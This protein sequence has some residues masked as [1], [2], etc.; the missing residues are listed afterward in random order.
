MTQEQ[1]ALVLPLLKSAEMRR[2]VYAL[3]KNLPITQQEVEDLAGHVIRHT[4]SSNNSQS[5]RVVLLF[6]REHE[7]LW[8]IVRETLRPLTEKDK[9]EKTDQKV[10]GFQ[11]AAGTALF[12]E[13]MAVIRALQKK[14]P[15]Y[16]ERFPDWS[17]HGSA[18]NQYRLWQLL[19][20]AGA[21]ASLQH[22]NPIIDEAVKK[23]W[24]I[25]EDYRLRAQL[26]FGGVSEPAGEKTFLPVE[27]RLKVFGKAER[28]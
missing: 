21:G 12:F 14:L 6:G 5:A 27:E 20:A 19:A 23:R 16:K 17:E 2:S 26:V 10:S 24:N 15:L 1:S 9:W 13:D 8:E 7:A 3:N 11:A 28:Q 18:M 22:Y 25:P 4:P